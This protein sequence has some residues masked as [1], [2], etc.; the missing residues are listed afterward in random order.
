[1]VVAWIAVL[2]LA[3]AAAGCAKLPVRP[4]LPETRA[5]APAAGPLATRLQPL[6]QAH[7]GVSGFVMLSQGGD[8][9]AARAWLVEQAVSSLD[10]QSYIWRDDRTGRWLMQR[11]H[12]AAERGVRVRLLL[13]DNNAGGLDTLLAGLDAHERIEVRLFNPFPHRGL[14]RLW[15]LAVDFKRLNRRMHHKSWTADGQATIFGGRNVGDTYFGVDT[16]MQF[17]D[18]DA[19]AIGPVVGE[20]GQVF[21][22]YWNAASAYPLATIRP[23]ASAG[24]AEPDNE[25]A[26]AQVGP[27]VDALW[28][29]PGLSRWRGDEGPKADEF[30][31]GKATLVSDPPT[32]VLE[33]GRAD[34][35]LLPHL[36]RTLGRADRQIDLVSPYFVPGEQ[37]VA[38]L[39]G[40]R[41]QGVTVRVL[42]NSLAANDVIAV[43]AGYAKYREAV[44][45]GGTQ[46][47]ELKALPQEGE[48]PATGK[49]LGLGSSRASLHAKTFAVDGERVFI[50]SFNF[51]PRSAWLNT[52]M[53]VLLEHPGLARGMHRA[54]DDE[55]PKQ[56]WAV[57]LEDGALRWSAPAERG[58]DVR[59]MEPQASLWQRLLMRL[60][61]WLPIE[62][63]L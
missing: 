44:L 38:A 30:A 52:E 39:A 47:Y 2:V 35:T 19:L 60:L 40:L 20:V 1:L 9:F 31:W 6:A 25:A 57:T 42:T 36:L 13:D 4:D 29:R 41:E 15:D 34:A 12:A 10:V 48:Q 27:Y 11:L 49:L 37:G 59:V 53:G 45:Q 51:D 17:A 62:P 18:L 7:P 24:E 21:D 58:L 61:G 33:P 56:A 43:H 8:A 32:K 3:A 23:P 26:A 14:G 22:D 55:V 50:G 16:T 28:A 5:L 63:L 46:L 54:F